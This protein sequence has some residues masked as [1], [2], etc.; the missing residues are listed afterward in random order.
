MSAPM[1]F[2]WFESE[3]KRVPFVT[4]LISL[5]AMEIAEEA[6]AKLLKMKQIRLKKKNLTMIS[7]ILIYK[8]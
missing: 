6:E 3:K 5:K 8:K 7:E 4:I 1:V 2:H